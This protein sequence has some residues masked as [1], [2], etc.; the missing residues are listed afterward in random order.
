VRQRAAV[1][2][3]S[4]AIA[5]AIALAGCSPAG[6]V[7][8]STSGA[9]EPARTGTLSG[10]VRLWGG[11]LNPQTMKQALNGAPGPGWTVTVRQAGRRVAS[12]TSD[13]H[14]RFRV[15]LAPG[16]YTLDCSALRAV[17]VWPGTTT[18]VVCNVPVP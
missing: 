9:T 1:F 4:L 13:P 17:R 15:R 7:P 12:A 5:L 3:G 8:R 14:G 11:P 2:P 16:T 18:A 10:I 6:S